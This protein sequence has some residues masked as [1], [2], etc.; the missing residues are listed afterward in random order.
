MTSPPA[1]A[2]LRQ[3]AGLLS[4]ELRGRRKRFWQSTESLHCAAV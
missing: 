2:K 4:Q 1:R 3:R